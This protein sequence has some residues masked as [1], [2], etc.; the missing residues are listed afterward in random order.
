M[1]PAALGPAVL[2]PAACGWRCVHRREPP[3]YRSASAPCASALSI[4][5]PD[6]AQRQSFGSSPSTALPRSR[7]STG[8]RR[9]PSR[10]VMLKLCPPRP[11]AA[12]CCCR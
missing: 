2:G 11:D 8:P 6:A 9:L 4:R 10:A 12:A 3:H 5:A 7:R 1:S